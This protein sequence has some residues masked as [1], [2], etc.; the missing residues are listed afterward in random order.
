MLEAL[1]QKW[2]HYSDFTL[3]PPNAFLSEPW[4]QVLHQII[5]LDYQQPSPAAK[6]LSRIQQLEAILQ[7]ALQS[8]HIARKAIIP[9]Q[10]LLRRPKIRPL[11]G[12]WGVHNR[13]KTFV[14]DSHLLIEHS[15]VASLPPSSSCPS[16]EI[17]ESVPGEGTVA[18]KDIDEDLDFRGAYWAM[19]S[20]NHVWYSWAPMFT[21]FSAGNITEKERVAHSRAIFDARDKVVV[22]LYAGIG[23][24]TLVYLVHA[25]ARIVHA[26]EWNPWSV[27]GLCRGATKNGIEWEVTQDSTQVISAPSISLPSTTT[28]TT[29]ASSSS[30]HPAPTKPKSTRLGKLQVYPGDNASW[31]RCFENT[32]HH[33]N[34]GLIPSSEQG[35]VLAVRALCP[36]QGGFLHV[37]QNVRQGEEPEFERRLID[38][39][40]RLFD[41]WKLQQQQGKWDIHVRHVECVKSFA[42]MVYHYVFDVECRPPQP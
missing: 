7:D 41:I 19:T 27:E 24:F 16:R 40:H 23:Y 8:T 42:P 37:H 25:G 17:K 20:Q 29:A 14:E 2:E 35:W 3:L 10:D 12:D 18:P 1:P 39:L 6:P 9:V 30:S 4:P 31:I 11:A 15:P 36:I 28:T 32:A 33:V 21:M 5:H 26:C 34:L 38:E 22:D 13:F